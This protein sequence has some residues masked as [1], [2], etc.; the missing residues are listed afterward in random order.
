M[1]Y[2]WPLFG[3]LPFLGVSGVSLV[4]LLV[5][6]KRTLL[7]VAME[8]SVGFGGLPLFAGVAGFSA[9]VAGLVDGV[10][11]FLDGVAAF[12]DGVAAFLDGVAYNVFARSR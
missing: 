6:C 2:F 10:A 5:C 1:V 4:S 3:G 9:G 11:A 8:S 12:L 7:G